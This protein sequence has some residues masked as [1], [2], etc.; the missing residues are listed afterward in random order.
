MFWRRGCQLAIGLGMLLAAA[1]CTNWAMP[2][3]GPQS[4]DVR[5]HAQDEDSLPYALIKV[6]PQVIDLL[7]LNAPRLSTIFTDRRPPKVITF[8]IGDIVSVTVFEAASGGLFIPAEASVRPGNFVQL[9]NQ[10]VDSNGNITVPYAGA[11]RAL[12]RTP[13]EVQQSIVAAL[14]NRAIEPQAVVALIEQRTLIDQRAWR[15][16]YTRPVRGQCCRRKNP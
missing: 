10:A 7:A 2:T 14:K 15:G 6:T 5:Q 12:D 8:G 1:G 9:P 13:A 3:A 11:V 4:W 16:Q